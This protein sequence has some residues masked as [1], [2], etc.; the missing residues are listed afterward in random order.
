LGLIR[1]EATVDELEARARAIAAASSERITAGRFWSW[2]LRIPIVLAFLVA[3]FN[4]LSG[5]NAILYFAPASSSSPASP[6]RRHC[7]SRSAS[8]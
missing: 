8:V 2:R 3:F 5:I 1:P 6:R 4:Q 7:C